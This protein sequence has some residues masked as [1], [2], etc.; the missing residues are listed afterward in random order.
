MVLIIFVL[1]AASLWT[2]LP[3][4][5]V[6]MAATIVVAPGLLLR[7]Q[8]MAGAA[9]GGHADMTVDVGDIHAIHLRGVGSMQRG[10]SNWYTHMTQGL[11]PPPA[12]CPTCRGWVPASL[13]VA[14]LLGRRAGDRRGC[15]TILSSIALALAVTGGLGGRDSFHSHRHHRRHS[16]CP[17]RDGSE[18]RLMFARYIGGSAAGGPSGW[19][20]LPAWRWR[21]VTALVQSL[22]GGLGLVSGVASGLLLAGFALCIAQLG[23]LPFS[24]RQ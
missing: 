11:D 4:L 8:S 19:N 18:G 2:M 17:G 7:V 14:D 10:G 5:G 21:I 23:P 16:L 20:G 12:W 13:Q 3:F 9:A 6:D 15:A 1:I 24:R 22:A